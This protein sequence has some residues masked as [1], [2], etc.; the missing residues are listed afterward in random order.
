LSQS[1]QHIRA[2]QLRLLFRASPLVLGA[3]ITALGAVPLLWPEFDHELL[4]AWCAGIFLWTA[5]VLWLYRRFQ[6]ASA[7]RQEESRFAWLLAGSALL[8]GLLWGMFGL[9]FYAVSDVEAKGFVLFV[10]AAMTA[11][12]V[13]Y[14]ALHEPSCGIYIMT[15][16]MPLAIASFVQGGRVAI[17]LGTMLVAYNGLVMIVARTAS[18]SMGG[19]FSIQLHNA[20][21][22]DDLRKARDS[23]EAT[24]AAAEEASRVKSRFLANMSHELRTPLNA[25]IG[26]SELMQS[27]LLGGGDLERFRE[28]AGD[29]NMSGRHLLDLV[30]D[31]LDLSKLESG[32]SEIKESAVRLDRLIWS[33][34]N[35]MRAQ[36]N[37]KD[38]QL[39]LDLP[40]DL[41]RLFADG[42][43]V[44]Q[45]LINLLSNAVKFTERGGS[46]ALA[47]GIA[48]TGELWI[49]V[50]DS[51][52]GMAPGDIAVAFLPFRQVD[53]NNSRRYQGSGL[54]LPLARSFIEQ[55][56]GTLTL[57]SAPGRGTTATILLPATRVLP[58]E[59]A[60][61]EI[62]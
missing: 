27:P 2:L 39:L 17:A 3:P 61:R 49:K 52:I 57:E 15:S 35:L 7:A 10:V 58:E 59:P 40:P 5:A 20:D 36:A 56:G 31:I 37:Q 4:L 26:F 62:A 9:A 33:C 18:R 60:A 1:K 51:G 55:H 42:L 22:V 24:R 54:G 43:R 41:P 50:R 11:G 44:K 53:N 32:N 48:A 16:T 34:T 46:V 8:A 25:I 28:Y 29:I 23:A 6:A 12:G 21:L 14:Y 38:I 47:A 45:V 13:L 19:M 30:N